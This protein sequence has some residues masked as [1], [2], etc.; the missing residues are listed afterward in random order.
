MEIQA[1]DGPSR[2]D[3]VKA[4]GSIIVPLSLIC[5]ACLCAYWGQVWLAAVFVAPGVIPKTI[6][7]F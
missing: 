3:A 7:A 1:E 5:A 6:A 4:Y 2:D